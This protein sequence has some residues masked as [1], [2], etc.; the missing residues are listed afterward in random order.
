MCNARHSSRIQALQ[1]GEEYRDQ[2]DFRRKVLCGLRRVLVVYPTARVQ[3]VRG[4]LRLLPPR[5]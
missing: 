3:Q 4:G 1:L 5:G 2:R